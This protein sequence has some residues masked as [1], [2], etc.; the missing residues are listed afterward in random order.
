[1]IPQ[2]QI[3][4][5]PADWDSSTL[6]AAG[7]TLPDGRTLLPRDIIARDLPPDLLTIWH[8]AVDTISTLDPGGWA[9]TLII[10]RRGETAEPPAAEDGLNAAPIVIPHL[11]LTIDRRWDDGATAPPIT[12]TYP[13]PYMLHFFDIL[14]AASYWVA[15]A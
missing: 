1:M 12:Q 10:A 7:I 14:T 15:D 11:T 13:D 8:G 9:A 5:C 2:L 4:C 3:T 6:T